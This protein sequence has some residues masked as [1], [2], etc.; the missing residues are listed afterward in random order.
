MIATHS[1]KIN[2]KWYMAGE[3][4]SP[5]TKPES[6]QKNINKYTKTEINRM[7]TYQLKE[8]AKNQGIK[9]YN[10]MT[11]GELKKYFIDFYDL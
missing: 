3:N 9:D 4:F 5:A 8:L 1:I 6:N 11:G 7:S 2:G 10:L